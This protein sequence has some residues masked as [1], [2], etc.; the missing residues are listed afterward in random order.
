[1]K[2]NMKD[3]SMT[4][5]FLV[6]LCAMYVGAGL[7][8]LI[9]VPAMY[10]CCSTSIIYPVYAYGLPLGLFGV[11]TLWALKKAWKMGLK[12]SEQPRDH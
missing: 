12:Q 8:V 1:M 11:I 7:L 6:K 9:S 3:L 10:W 4:V 2:L 5:K